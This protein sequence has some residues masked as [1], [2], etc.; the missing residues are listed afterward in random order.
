MNQSKSNKLWKNKDLSES[1]LLKGKALLS[2]DNRKS[3]ILHLFSWVF[4][5]IVVVLIAVVITYFM[6]QVRINVGSS[7]EVTMKDQDKVLI[8]T[9]KYKIGA[10]KRGEVIAFK[11]NGNKNSYSYIRRVIG[12]PGETIQIKEG[13]I[14]I[15]G[16]VLLEQWDLPP[17]NFSGIAEEEIT[18]DKDEVFVLGDNRN[19]SEDSRYAYIDNIKL[20]DIEGK[21]WYVISPKERFG[22]VKTISSTWK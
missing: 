1:R 21:V 8:N 20:D 12:L 3:F 16:K 15:N 22:F 14:Y 13:I 9:L 19:N 5:I 17:M 6:G 10:P 7:M 18:L 2:R 11:P 4:L